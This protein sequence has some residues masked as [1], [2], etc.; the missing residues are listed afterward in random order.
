MRDGAMPVH[1]LL[2][3]PSSTGKSYTLTIIKKLLPDEAHCTVDAGSPRII[4]YNDADLQHRVLI[5]GESD[6]LPAGE[7]NRPASAIRNLLQDHHL[8]YEVTI[9]DPDTGDY[10]TREV[11]KPVPTVLITTSTKSLGEQLMTRLFTLEI[12]AS[13][14]QIGAALETQAA[15]ETEGS[16]PPDSALVAYQSYLQLKAP[17][18]VVVPFAGEL[19]KAIGKMASAPRIFRDYARLLSLIKSTAIIRHHWRETDGQGRLVATLTDYETVRTL[20]NDMYIDSST[21]ATSEVRKLVEAVK[22]LDASRTEGERITVMKLATYLDVSKMAA[23]R[24]AKKALKED[25]ILNRESRTGYPANFTIGEPMPGVEGLPDLNTV[26]DRN[27][28]PVT[29]FS[30]KKGDCNAV[31]PLTDGETPTLTTG[32]L[33]DCPACGRNEWTYTPD[34]EL[35]CPCGNKIKGSER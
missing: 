34:G 32:E 7:D 4:I 1:L 20:V 9:R 13:K 16:S 15:L 33:P 14:E 11:N 12:S 17:W 10:T 28:P 27:T 22:A 29:D 30:F 26:T 5:F 3:G 24:R 31:T 35:L 18:K 6:S 19:A 25:W 23:S 2:T 21:G 8:H